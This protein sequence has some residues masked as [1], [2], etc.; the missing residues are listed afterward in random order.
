M[1]SELWVKVKDTDLIFRIQEGDGSNLLPEDEYDGYV[2]YIYYEYWR[3]HEG[4]EFNEEKL[5]D[6]G[7]Y[8]GGQLMLTEDFQSKYPRTRDC[9][10]DV[11]EYALTGTVEYE[12]LSE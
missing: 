10:K 6:D 8:D 3:V 2:D 1:G 5:M 4:T 7:G 11:L 9:I 12:I